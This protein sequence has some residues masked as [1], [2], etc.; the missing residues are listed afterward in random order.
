MQT[1]DHTEK[2]CPTCFTNIQL[3]GYVNLTDAE[4]NK[5]K[6][7]PSPEEIERTCQTETVMSAFEH[8]IEFRLLTSTTK[9]PR[10]A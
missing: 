10:Q 8:G 1:N 7:T 2:K 6:N 9:P 4:A 3:D 5:T